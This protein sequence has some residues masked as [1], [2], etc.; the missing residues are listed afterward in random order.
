MIPVLGMM[1]GAYIITR[2][3]HLLMDEKPH[4]L[5]CVCAGATILAALLGSAYF[6]LAAFGIF[7]LPV[8]Q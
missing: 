7:K 3:L 2:M 1:V 4:G 8:I 6:L 5:V